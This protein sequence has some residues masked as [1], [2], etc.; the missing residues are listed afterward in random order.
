MKTIL[1]IKKMLNY[2]KIE[3]FNLRL[4]ITIK[5]NQMIEQK[6]II[7]LRKKRLDAVK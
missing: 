2:L 1:P 4:R 5:K 7:S 6:M 3:K